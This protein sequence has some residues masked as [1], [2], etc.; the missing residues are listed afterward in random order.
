MGMCLLTRVEDTF[1][2]DDVI[3]VF[4]ANKNKNKTKHLHR[5]AR[6]NKERSE[7]LGSQH[8]LISNHHFTCLWNVRMRWPLSLHS[9][10]VSSWGGCSEGLSHCRTGT[11]LILK[12][13]KGMSQLPVLVC[14]HSSLLSQPQASARGH[15]CHAAPRRCHHLPQ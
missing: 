11:S 14:E 7:I 5:K 3:M 9:P 8:H 4:L 13:R 12:R 2:M 6:T 10:C 15:C 1:I